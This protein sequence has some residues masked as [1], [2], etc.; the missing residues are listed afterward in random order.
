VI[1]RIP[2]PRESVDST[3]ATGQFLVTGD[4]HVDP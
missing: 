4:R 1:V 2:Q 3:T